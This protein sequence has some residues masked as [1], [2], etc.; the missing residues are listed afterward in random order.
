MLPSVVVR[1]VAIGR[2]EWVT[3]STPH[4]GP[5]H[6]SIHALALITP[7]YRMIAHCRSRAATF[8]WTEFDADCGMDTC[9]R[10]GSYICCTNVDSHRCNIWE[11][12][13]RMVG[14]FYNACIVVGDKLNPRSRMFA[15]QVQHID[16]TNAHQGNA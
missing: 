14:A 12:H 4:I 3:R 9:G 2:C 15:S 8:M 10:I 16:V 5:N 11:L 6:D 13:P 1:D 7:Y